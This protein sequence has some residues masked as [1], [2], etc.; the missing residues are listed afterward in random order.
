MRSA[1]YSHIDHLSAVGI[2]VDFAWLCLMLKGLRRWAVTRLVSFLSVFCALSHAL[3]SLTPC[4]PIIIC[5]Y[6]RHSSLPKGHLYSVTERLPAA[7]LALTEQGALKRPRRSRT[8]RT[9][10]AP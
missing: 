6:E 5:V 1:V 8:D 7:H 2:L 4:Q 3:N 9:W 10:S